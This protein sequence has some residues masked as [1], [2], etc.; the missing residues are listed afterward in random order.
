ME[1]HSYDVRAAVYNAKITES[2]SPFTNTKTDS[3]PH[4]AVPRIFLAVGPPY[5]LSYSRS[6]FFLSSFLSQCLSASCRWVAAAVGR[7]VKLLPG[8]CR[9]EYRLQ[10]RIF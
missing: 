10:Y 5:F 4:F 8:G 3:R 6:G 9:F 2:K 1:Q 7:T